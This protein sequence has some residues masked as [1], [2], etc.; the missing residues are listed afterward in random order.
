MSYFFEVGTSAQHQ[1]FHDS[2][3]SNKANSSKEVNF[4]N[5]FFQKSYFLETTN[6]SEKHY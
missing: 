1:I 2:Y 3:F 4:K 6:F 5:S